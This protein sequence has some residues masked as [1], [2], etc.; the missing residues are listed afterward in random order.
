[1]ATFKEGARV[2]S[3]FFESPSDHVQKICQFNEFEGNASLQNALELASDNFKA[4]PQYGRREVLIVFSSL[5]NC[6][7]GDI[8]QTVRRLVE[9]DVQVEQLACAVEIAATLASEGQTRHDAGHLAELF[10]GRL[11]VLARRIVL[12]RLGQEGHAVVD[13][14]EG[15]ETLFLLEL[16]QKASGRA[17]PAG[18]PRRAREALWPRGDDARAGGAVVTTRSTTAADDHVDGEATGS[19]KGMPKVYDAGN[20]CGCPTA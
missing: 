3:D 5:T 11:K 18:P 4:I 7:P 19:L 1:M 2:L 20:W 6:D 8:Q 13:M 9:L 12:S 14:V 10:V 17:A 15:A 16:A